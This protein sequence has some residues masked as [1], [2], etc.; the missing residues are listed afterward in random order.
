MDSRLAAIDAPP[1]YPVTPIAHSVLR[2][3]K[4]Y[5]MEHVSLVLVI[6]HH[7]LMEL[8]INANL[9][10]ISMAQPAPLAAVNAELALVLTLAMNVLVVL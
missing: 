6:V 9:E 2:V 10:T 4:N 1:I 3:Q 7:A 5:Q 8:A